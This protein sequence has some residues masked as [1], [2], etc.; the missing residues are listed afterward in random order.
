VKIRGLLTI[1]SGAALS[2]AASDQEQRVCQE[3]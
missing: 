1:L 3:M 2:G